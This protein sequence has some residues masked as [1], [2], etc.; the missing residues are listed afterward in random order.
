MP[1]RRPPA[2]RY[3]DARLPQREEPRRPGAPR[4]QQ[5]G[6]GNARSQSAG[7]PRSRS[8]KRPKQQKLPKQ[9]S[10]RTSSYAGPP[11]VTDKVLTLPNVLSVLRLLG[12]PVFLV[13]ALVQHDDTLALAVLV[14]AGLTD[15]LD[16]WLA[17]RLRQVSRIGALLDPV[18]DRCYV[19]AVVLGMA[20]RGVIPWWFAVLLPLRDVLLLGLVPSLRSRGLNVLPVHF[21]GKAATFNLLIAFPLLYFAHSTGHPVDAS[22]QR[23]HTE[24]ASEV[25]RALGWAF[26]GWG[27]GLY[28]WAGFLYLGQVRR[29]L[30]TVPPLAGAAKAT[31]P[32]PAKAARAPKSAKPS[33]P[34][35]SAK[36][37][38]PRRGGTKGGPRRA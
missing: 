8:T 14:L 12:V 30:A 26:A 38:K 29:L 35:K 9:K 24:I 7:R 6:R 32:K 21:L 22:L 10:T 4:E 37:S 17:R 15:L 34:S 28:W 13:A 31:S 27:A 18:A 1:D 23:S 25:A 20:A 5:R 33:K 36:S 2:R 19:L 3:A 16:G 11:V